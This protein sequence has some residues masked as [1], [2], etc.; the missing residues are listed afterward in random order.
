MLPVFLTISETL[1]NEDFTK[2]GGIKTSVTVNTH[3]TSIILVNFFVILYKASIN[4]ESV[5]L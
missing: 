4:Y 5:V 2:K 3:P 1:Q